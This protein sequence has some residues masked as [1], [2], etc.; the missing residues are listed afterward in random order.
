MQEKMA[1]AGQ[2][3][4]YAEGQEIISKYLLVEVSTTQMQRVT[5]T[6]G[7]LMEQQREEEETSCEPLEIKSDEVVYAQADGSMIFT[8]EEGWK[9]VKVGRIFKESD[10]LEVGGKRGWIRHSEYDAYLGE[11]K[12][13]A[14]RFEQKVEPYRHLDARLIFITD[15]A[16]WIKNWIEDA[17]PRALQILDWYHAVEHLGTFA[18]EYFQ[19][20]A[21]RQQWMEDQKSLLRN[22]QPESVIDNIKKLSITKSRIKGIRKNLIAY[23]ESNKKRMDY[24]KYSSIGAG[25]IGSGAIEAA[26]R[27]VVQKRLKQSGQRWSKTG[28]QHVLALRCAN[29]SQRWSDV[30]ELISQKRAA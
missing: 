21:L 15:G 29:L 6:Y 10:C 3:D 2:S 11:S 5:N 1:Y 28:A 16:V 9:E 25:I 12:K 27:T 20:A 26:H 13:F 17:Y 14:W 19:D 30:V 24:K 7:K 18:S 4:C 8:R 23:Y 22:S